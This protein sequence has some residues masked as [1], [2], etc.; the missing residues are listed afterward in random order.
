MKMFS[1]I[2]PLLPTLA[3]IALSAPFAAFGAAQDIV[4]PIANNILAVSRIAVTI[5]FVLSIVVFGWGIVK[6]I[7]AA[8]DPTA[9]EKAKQFLYWGVIGMAIGASLFGL[10]TFLR[11]YFG[12][13]AGGLVITPPIVL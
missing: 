10:I 12:V 2:K 9:V 6:F 8:G 11:T 7:T 3:L 1:R 4:S 13:E 5:V